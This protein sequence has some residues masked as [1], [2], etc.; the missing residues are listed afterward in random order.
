MELV[1]RRCGGHGARHRPGTVHWGQWFSVDAL[2][3]I[4]GM[5]PEYAARR[6]I[7]AQLNA[8]GLFSNVVTERLP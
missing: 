6:E 2:P 8:S 7:Y 1:E 4:A 5:Y 3:R